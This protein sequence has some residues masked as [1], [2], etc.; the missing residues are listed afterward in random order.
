MFPLDIFKYMSF[1][2]V[3]KWSEFIG[4]I[5]ESISHL[6]HLNGENED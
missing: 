2:L 5:E 1:L 6:G 4:N 3:K